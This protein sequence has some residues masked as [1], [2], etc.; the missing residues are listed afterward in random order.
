MSHTYPS[1]GLGVRNAYEN[2][3]V[4]KYRTMLQVKKFRNILESYH[5]IKQ[6]YNMIKLDDRIFKLWYS[7][8]HSLPPTCSLKLLTTPVTFK[9]G[10]CIYGCIVISAFDIT[11][12]F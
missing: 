2:G 5:L 11:L 7:L 12:F 9:H 3:N 4:T 8:T 10:L 1:G 6:K